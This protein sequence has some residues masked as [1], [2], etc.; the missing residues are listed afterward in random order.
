MFSGISGGALVYGLL[1]LAV[2]PTTISTCVVFTQGSGGDTVSALFNSAFANMLGIIISPFLL[3]LFLK[4]TSATLSAGQMRS[5]FAGLFWKMVVPV[6][7]G[8]GVRALLGPISKKVKSR[9][10]IASS[11]LILCMV[12]ITFS[13]VASDEEFLSM[14]GSSMIL[15]FL[16]LA[17]SHLILVALAYGGATLLRFPIE[18]RITVLFVAPQKTM[19]LGVPLLSVYFANNPALLGFALLPLLFYHPWQLIVA[20]VLRS[21]VL[22]KRKDHEIA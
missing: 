13:G 19:A 20:G 3:S 10:S 12:L 15:P 5:V 18:E 14:L 11:S 7:A 21:V 22:S 16:F 17:L 6:L 1:A 8:Q 4:G 2:L 9:L